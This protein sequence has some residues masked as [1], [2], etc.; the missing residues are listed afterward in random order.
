MRTKQR[1]R[2]EAGGS[3]ADRPSDY[4]WDASRNPEMVTVFAEIVSTHHVSA[5]KSDAET[6]GE[7]QTRLSVLAR[8]D[9]PGPDKRVWADVYVFNQAEE[10]LRVSTFGFYY[11]EPVGDGDY[12]MLDEIVYRQ[13]TGSRGRSA[14]PSQAPPVKVKYRL[15]CWAGDQLLTD[16]ILHRGD[17]GMAVD[18]A[19]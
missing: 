3:A 9:Y 11:L 19:R 10:V 14:H 16:G 4:R 12:F 1:T 8:V 18:A 13:P 6:A 17:H 15:Y 7:L 5:S 2:G